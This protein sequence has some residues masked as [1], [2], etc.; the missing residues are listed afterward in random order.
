MQGFAPGL[1][2]AIAGACTTG[3]GVGAA[4]CVY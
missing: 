4:F 2:A 1:G 3:A